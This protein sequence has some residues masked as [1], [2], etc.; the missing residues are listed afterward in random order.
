M[1][2]YLDIL[3]QY[4]GYD[5]FRGIQAEIINSIS[6]SKDTLGL[7]PTGG[8]K[9]VCFQVP[10][11]DMDGLCLVITPLI[12]LMKDQVSRLKQREIKAETIYSGMSHNDVLR[13]L[14]NCTYGD[15]KFLYV[16]P[17]RLESE[18]FR[19]RLVQMP[20]ISMICVDEAH[21][22][23]QWGYDFRPSYLRI[24]EVRNLFSY[25]IPI[26]AL[27][28]TATPDVVKDIQDKLDF[29]NGQVF[30]MSFERKNLAYI[31]RQTEDKT[32]EMLHILHS[33]TEGSAIVY[34]R[35]RKL[36]SEIARLLI[37]NG[38]SADNYHAGLTEAERSLRQINWTKGRNR[39]MVATNAFGMGID[40]PNV[41]L[42]IHYN[43]PDS[44]EAYFQEAGRAGRD[45]TKSYAVLLY[46]SI[47]KQILHKRI[48]A[49]YPDKDY[50]KNTYENLCCFLQIGEGEGINR[51]Y[52]FPIEK[53]CN[54]FHQF[55]VET[56]SALRILSTA[57]YIDY[58][59]DVDN[60]SRIIFRLNKDELYLLTDNG[61]NTD[62]LI[63][64]LLR[65]Y[66]GLF[67]D[68]TYIEETLL[69]E[70]TGLKPDVVY[71]LLK[72]L[73]RRRVIEYIP[74][75]DIP[76]ITFLTNRIDK[77]RIILSDAVYNRR[78]AEYTKRINEI[79]EYAAT[80][81]KCRSRMLLYYFGEKNTKDCG[82][83][84]VCLSQRNNITEKKIDTIENR[85]N[86][87]LSDGQFH[88][89]SE[90]TTLGGNTETIKSVIQQM[91]FEEEL[92]V[93]D[94]KIRLKQA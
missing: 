47:D 83:C 66:T 45:G 7:M 90:I 21:C 64:T 84:D 94:D 73:S 54:N 27:T 30:S 25:H 28:A 61:V 44:I 24:A 17:E 20:K 85:I 37:A 15:F 57:R 82:Q 23:S 56:N 72:E 74:R 93:K 5:S 26:L 60:R 52:P 6:S 76:T 10:A 4:W 75:S 11:L 92:I 32:Q 81:N 41:R 78:K 63:R 80:K 46:N 1:Q 39:V 33:V 89:L 70:K 19:E 14:D 9:S 43:I 8:G 91:I 29:R 12:S 16:S 36:T 2:K 38:I 65:T 51:T 31:V 87:I 79:L 42:V 50:I 3:K 67:S 48:P 49:N 62:N 53:F 58:N 77:Q 86:M 40:K 55:L 34:T 18:L 35:N 59:E 13:V 69:A 22:V 68:Y 71:N 88:K